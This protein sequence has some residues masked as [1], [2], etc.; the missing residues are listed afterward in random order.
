M[1]HHENVVT[2]I[3]FI[4]AF[5]NSLLVWSIPCITI[6]KRIDLCKLQED[7]PISFG[8]ERKEKKIMR[9]QMIIMSLMKRKGERKK[10]MIMNLQK[11]NIQRIILLNIM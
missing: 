6:A 10:T 11:R 8:D 1:S 3:A 9:V 4:W 7:L 5:V 2:L